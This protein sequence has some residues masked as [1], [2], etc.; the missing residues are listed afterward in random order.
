M[1]SVPEPPD[2]LWA[3]QLC[4]AF[5]SCS[6]KV[7]Q[8]F[9]TSHHARP[10]LYFINTHSSFL[11]GS[12]YLYTGDVILK[13]EKQIHPSLVPSLECGEKREDL[14]QLQRPSL[15]LSDPQPATCP[16]T[17]RLPDSSKNFFLTADSR[18][19]P[20]TNFARRVFSLS[21]CP[22]PV[23]VRKAKVFPWLLLVFGGGLE[24]EMGLC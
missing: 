4:E 23:N 15:Y 19:E 21:V 3:H 18:T 24:P 2:S 10:V 20:C 5:V 8:L 22:G 6:V 16:A 11:G 1:Q 9:I 13:Y 12:P 17:C 7:K 14:P